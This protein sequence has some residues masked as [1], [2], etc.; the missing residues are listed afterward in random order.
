MNDKDKKKVNTWDEKIWV[1]QPMQRYGLDELTTML[2]PNPNFSGRKHKH[3]HREE[4]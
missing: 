4:P 1:T 3:R 2:V